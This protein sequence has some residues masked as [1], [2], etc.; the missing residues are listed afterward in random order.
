MKLSPQEIQGRLQAQ[1]DSVCFVDVRSWDEFQSGHV[2]GAR[3]LPLDRLEVSLATLPKDRLILL[4]CQSGRRSQQAFEKLRTLGFQNLAELEGGFSAWQAAGLPVAAAR[5]AAIP[6]QRQVMIAAGAL[7]AIGTLLG[8]FLHPG[9][10]VL[11]A[12][13]GFGLFQAGL[14]GWC[15]LGML[16]EK[17][18][19][20][21]SPALRS[22]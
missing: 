13:V 20:N 16:L 1:Q 18:P 5:R 3:C 12:F 9:F 6:V 15:G 11:P 17:M 4:G 7:V 8:A 14:T 19:W 2:P 10:W 22:P 21:R